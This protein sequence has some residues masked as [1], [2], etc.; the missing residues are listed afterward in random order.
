MICCITACWPCCCLSP[1]ASMWHWQF[2]AHPTLNML[3]PGTSAFPQQ[4]HDVLYSHMLTYWPCHHLFLPSGSVWPSPFANL[5]LTIFLPPHLQHVCDPWDLLHN[6]MLIMSPSILTLS[7]YVTVMIFCTTHWPFLCLLWHSGGMWPFWLTAPPHADHAATSFHFQRVSGPDCLLCNPILT[8]LLPCLIHSKY[9][10][11]TIYCTTQCWPC[12][13]LL[14]LSL[15]GSM[16]PLW[17]ALPPHTD[18][19]ATSFHCQ[20]VCDPACLLHNLLLTVLP[21]LLILSKYVKLV[22]CCTTC[23]SPCHCLLPLSESACMWPSQL[24]AQPHAN[25]LT[26][27][28]NPQEVCDPCGKL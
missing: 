5:A 15:S 14:P 24:T 20:Q 3:P 4:V 17:L 12:H 6:L 13:C 10:K 19:A 9:V 8:V 26:T 2:T 23:Y 25:N 22:V 1:S 18:H 21:P 7:E 11:L 16:W 27:S 28:S